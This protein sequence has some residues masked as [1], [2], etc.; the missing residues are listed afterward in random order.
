MTNSKNNF[1]FIQ[2]TLV[3]VR[4]CLLLSV[5]WQLLQAYRIGSKQ[6]GF[7]VRVM[8]KLLVFLQADSLHVIVLLKCFSHF[9]QN[10]FICVC[11]SHNWVWKWMH[12]ED[13]QLSK[14]K[15]MKKRTHLLAVILVH[16]WCF[17]A[18]GSVFKTEWFIGYYQLS[19]CF[20][21]L[22]LLAL[23]NC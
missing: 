23:Q 6:L 13:F 14:I 7:I 17:S 19:L 18:P 3:S 21:S 16:L 5:T 22:H 4:A 9:A 1:P 12:F 10:C 15:L 20:I 2:E 11:E 8:S